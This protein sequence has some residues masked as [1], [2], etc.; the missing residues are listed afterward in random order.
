MNAQLKAYLI[1]E[2]NMTVNRKL[3]TILPAEYKAYAIVAVNLIQVAIAFYDPSY[4]S[5]KL[6]WT[7]Q[8]YLGAVARNKAEKVD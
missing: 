4:T 3:W 6:G 8:T 5:Q 1:K 2:I 7:K